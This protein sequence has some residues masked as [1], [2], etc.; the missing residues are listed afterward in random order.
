MST[1]RRVRDVPYEVS[2]AAYRSKKVLW[3]G[4]I[5]SGIVVL[6]AVFDGIS[7]VVKESHVIQASA[8]L[9]FSVDVIA[10]IGIALLLCTLA[11]AIPRTAILGAIL[12]TG[13]LGGAAASQVRIGSPWSQTLF[14]VVFAILVWAGVFLRDSRLRAL[15]PVR[16]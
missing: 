9:G 7:K 6:F 1:A 12:L 14:P 3:P 16:K 10:G 15:L 5:I 11:Y 8:Q 4:R 2:H 13:Y